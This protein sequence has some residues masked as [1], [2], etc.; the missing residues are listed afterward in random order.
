MTQKNS[1]N[2][3]M[4]SQLWH[5]L[6]FSATLGWLLLLC[7]VLQQPHLNHWQNIVTHA[8]PTSVDLRWKCM[9][10]LLIT[11]MEWYSVF[12]TNSSLLPA[13]PKC[14]FCILGNYLNNLFMHSA[15]YNCWSEMVLFAKKNNQGN[16]MKHLLHSKSNFIESVY[17]TR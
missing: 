9:H 10:R 8:M 16:Q 1:I 2:T 4:F 12:M 14:L 6:P 13:F 15:I 5:F 3:M 7:P 11:L 17:I